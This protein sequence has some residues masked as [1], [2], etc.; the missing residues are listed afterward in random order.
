MHPSSFATSFRKRLCRWSVVLQ[1]S[2]LLVL[3]LQPVV[4]SAEQPPSNQ[5]TAVPGVLRVFVRDGCPHCIAA[6]E[7]LARL[8]AERPELH[9]VYRAVD[10]DETARSELV[11]LSRNAGRWPP[12]V[13]SFAVDGR[14]MVGFADAAQSGDSLVALLD[15]TIAPSQGLEP[16]WIGRID[17]KR[18]GLPLFTLALGLLD[19]FNP[20]AIWVLLFLLSLLVRLNDRRRMALV[21]GTFVVTSGAVYYAFLAAW[22]NIFL[23]VGL[24][25]SIRWGL[26]TLA[27]VIGIV[28]VKDF[29]AWKKWFTLSIPES[30][31]PGLYARVRRVLRAE[32][33][34]ASMLAVAGLAI[35]VNFVELLCTAGFPAVYTAVLT[36]HQLSP[37][38]Y[39]S[40]LGLYI[41]AYMADDTLMV[42]MAV[43]ALS[44]R[45]LTENAGRWLKLLSGMVMLALGLAMM[46]RPD[47]LM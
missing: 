8:T 47:W 15:A 17:A 43:F 16:P 30:A 45:K 31:K 36:Q 20:C 10:R 24:S 4:A 33:L 22:L 9:V 27:V 18:L 41:V 40:Y 44:S 25:E 42:A 37:T 32:A 2:A 7:F 38:A 39:Y 26:A 1:R 12:G 34:P 29:F 21:A 5:S 11:E 28:N 46:A 23:A 35:V 13:P 3:L 6:E 19:G 14:L